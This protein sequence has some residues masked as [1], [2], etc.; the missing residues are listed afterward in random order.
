MRTGQG[1]QEDVPASATE[2]LSNGIDRG[3]RDRHK[4]V[5]DNFRVLGRQRL[6][7]SVGA[8]DD[9]ILQRSDKWNESANW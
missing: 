4:S 8:E 7:A 5:A 1:L 3:I 6:P 2:H 9:R